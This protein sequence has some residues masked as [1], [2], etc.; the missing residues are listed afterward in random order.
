MLVM[1]S[2]IYMQRAA[3]I[4][5]VHVHELKSCCMVKLQLEMLKS[6]ERDR[7]LTGMSHCTAACTQEEACATFL[8]DSSQG[9][10]KQSLHTSDSFNVITSISEAEP[11]QT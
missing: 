5:I 2:L 4:G 10:S 8:T 3:D 7:C 9:C 6:T 11:L 1:L